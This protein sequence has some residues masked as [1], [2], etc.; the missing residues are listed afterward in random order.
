M[1]KKLLTE[2]RK[3]NQKPTRLGATGLKWILKHYKQLRD[4]FL[5]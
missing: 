2:L 1:A 5:G 3:T 4:S